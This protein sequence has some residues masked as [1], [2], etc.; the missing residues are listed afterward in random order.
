MAKF[1][2]I[3]IGRNEGKRLG[4]CIK[5]VYDTLKYN[6]LDKF[7]IIYVDSNSADN[8]IEVAR[9]F[10]EVKVFKVTGA[11]NAA[12][13]RNIGAGETDSDYLCFIDGDMEIIP[14][15][16][17]QIL[18]PDKELIY[19]FISGQFHN[20]Y[21]DKE[22]NFLKYEPYHKDV[23]ENDK[24]QV[25]T[26][27]LF[28][29]KRVHWV[30]LKGMRS[31]FRT[32]EDLDFG[33]RMAKIGIKLL[34]KKNLMAKHF[35]VHYKSF[36]RMWVDLWGGRSN[37]RAVLYR[38]HLNNPH[39]IKKL[40]K[41]DP[42][43]ILLILAIIGTIIFWN[44]Y[45]LLGYASITFILCLIIEHSGIFKFL[46]R[47]FYQIARDFVVLYSIFFFFPKDKELQ[48]IKIA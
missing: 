2:F 22:G 11:T 48:Y 14:E 6:N 18:T 8:S 44:F 34:R 37:N 3:I 42:S 15:F 17:K 31:R 29:V 27:G 41:S 30:K 47:Y 24:Y 28:I 10:P 32:C 45:F 13:G 46:N 21:H 1:G 33:L 7:D 36:N 38:N 39:I 43:F 23:L 9:Q 20:Y 40:L 16:F 12:V 35:T 5:S 19:D 26:G 25:T 4:N